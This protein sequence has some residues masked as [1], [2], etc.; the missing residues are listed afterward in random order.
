[1]RLTGWAPSINH[2]ARRIGKATRISI[3]VR[4]Q[5]IRVQVVD[6]HREDEHQRCTPTSG[7]VTRKRQE[8]EDR[9][10]EPVDQFE[11][12]DTDLGESEQ[13][14]ARG[15]EPEDARLF[16]IEDIPV[17]HRTVGKLPTVD[18]EQRLITGEGHREAQTPGQYHE[19][20]GQGVPCGGG[21]LRRAT[22]RDRLGHAAGRT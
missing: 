6:D 22:H 11:Q 1:M 14:A 3:W 7:E 5:E 8:N 19:G 9:E 20:Y 12:V 17:Q 21:L 15:V 2:Q 4:I 16:D 10:G 18:G 13:P